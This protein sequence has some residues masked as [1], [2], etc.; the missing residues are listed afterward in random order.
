MG[1]PMRAL[2]EFVNLTEWDSWEEAQ[3][4]GI[5]LDM[6][7]HLNVT[8]PDGT[9]EVALQWMFERYHWNVTLDVKGLVIYVHLQ[10]GWV[11]NIRL[12]KCNFCDPEYPLDME[13]YQHVF[14]T[15][16]APESLILETIFN[17]TLK[18]LPIVWPTELLGLV[19]MTN[20]KFKYYDGYMYMGSDMSW[21]P[22]PIPHKRIADLPWPDV[23]HETESVHM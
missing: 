3:Q 12:I 5:V 18:T 14:N 22:F 21:I 17:P 4:M 23:N 9:E 20:L 13:L 10:K 6:L 8:M 16:L 19:A 7:M 2:F 15:V 11:E 1:L